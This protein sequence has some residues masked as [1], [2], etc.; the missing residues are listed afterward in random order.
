MREFVWRKCNSNNTNPDFITLYEYVHGTRTRL[1][2][3]H[4]AQGI[5]DRYC[6]YCLHV[7]YCTYA[8]EIQPTVW[9]VLM[10]LNMTFLL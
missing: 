8:L 6:M 3:L 1:Q 5:C 4:F 2:Q 10:V 9:L 7:L